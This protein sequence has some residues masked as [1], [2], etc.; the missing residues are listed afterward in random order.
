MASATTT[1]TS[2]SS[3]FRALRHRNFRLYWSGQLIS[4]VGTWMQSVAQGWLMHRLTP[5]AFMLGLLGF[6]QFLPVLPLA[7]YAGV[8]ADHMDK[9]RL[10][11]ITQSLL[12]L[13]AVV[14]AALAGTGSIRPW[15]V[16]V[17]AGV[18]GTVNTFD[19]P[20]RQSFVIEMTG[21]EDLA[22]GIALNSAAFNTARILGP[23]IGGLLL[24][25]AGEGTCFWLN[26]LSFLAVIVGL[27]MMRIETFVAP[28]ESARS[29]RHNLTEGVRYAWSREPIRNLLILLAVCAGL[30]FQ[31]NVLLPVYTRD[32][33]HAGP[34]VYGLLLAGFGAGSLVA[35][36][37]MTM[38]LDRWALRRQLL[39]GLLTGGLGMIGFAWVRWLPGMVAMGALAGFGLILYVS[40]TN[41]LIQMTTEDAFRGRVMSLYTLMFVGTA[42]FGSLMA[43]AVGE[44]WGA[45]MATTVCAVILLFGALWISRR[46][47]TLAA[48]EQA[49]RD[50]VERAEREAEPIT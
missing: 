43:G 29:I 31:F 14:F 33:M 26:A 27:A 34:K 38:R 36:G 8:V 19:M 13:Q 32:V 41:T 45:P 18:L 50:A 49:E 37:R 35:S 48:R 4:L 17:L 47:R 7:L 25:W 10:L 16:L 15:M 22:N 40:S 6:V 28:A 12:L 46:L 39:S 24:G 20:A 30:G 3:N 5:S 1:P 11:L 9:R 44:R 42:P 21:R 23:A 2:W